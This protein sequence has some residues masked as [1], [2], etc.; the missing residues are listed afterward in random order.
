M[1]C[2]KVPAI[3]IILEYLNCGELSYVEK[4]E[5][6]TERQLHSYTNATPQ[7]GQM[8]DAN[9]VRVSTYLV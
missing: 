8:C 6:Q 9:S 1:A 5:A 2:L 3:L 4:P 7:T